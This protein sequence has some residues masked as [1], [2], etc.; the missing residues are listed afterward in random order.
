M[1]R[2]LLR[3]TSAPLV[4]W[5]RSAEACSQLLSEFPDRVTVAATPREVVQAAGTTYCMLSTAEASVMVVSPQE[6]G[7]EGVERCTAGALHLLSSRYSLFY[8]CVLCHNNM[9]V[10]CTTVPP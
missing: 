2:N 10:E 7:R 8:M 3:K 5:N 6:G 4:V 1:V 9:Y